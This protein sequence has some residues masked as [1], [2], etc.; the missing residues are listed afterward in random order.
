MARL[1]EYQKNI[2]CLLEEIHAYDIS[3]HDGGVEEQIIF[4]TEHDHYLLIDLG[5]ERKQYVYGAIVHI[6]IKDGKIWIQRNNTEI[7]LA[8]RL[9]EMGVQKEKIVIGFQSPFTRQF[10]GYAVG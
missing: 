1:T 4:D 10:S 8:D 9:V 7:N 5:W 6:D 3:S 2:R